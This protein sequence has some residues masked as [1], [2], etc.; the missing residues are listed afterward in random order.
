[1]DAPLKFLHKDG[2][3]DD[4]KHGRSAQALEKIRNRCTITDKGCWEYPGLNARGYGELSVN[5]KQRIAHRLTA[6]LTKPDF[7]RHMQVHHA[8][9]NRACCNPDH[10]RIVT[11]H[12][13]TAEMMER[14]HYLKRIADLESALSIAAPDHPL[15]AA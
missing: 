14:N 10:L 11:A 12:E 5:G 13:N 6:S 9:S 15:L 7:S 3:K 4:I 2:L 8:C 1:M